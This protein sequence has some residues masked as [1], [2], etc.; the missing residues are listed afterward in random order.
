M[1][2]K[3]DVQQTEEE[4][5]RRF[6]R[7]PFNADTRIQVQGKTYETKTIYN[8]AIG[9]CLV[10]LPDEIPVGTPCQVQI[11]LS[12]TGG[13]VTVRVEGEV[14]RSDTGMAAINFKKI[15]PDSLFH[16][17]N[18]IRYNAR[19]AEAVEEEIENHPGIL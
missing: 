8:L 11:I 12:R 4:N 5:K 6:T 10:S 14:V 1:E 13:G 19:D 2:E 9:G 15:D 16:L 17:R 7:V 18:I 3:K